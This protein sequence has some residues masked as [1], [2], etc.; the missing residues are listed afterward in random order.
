MTFEFRAHKPKAYLWFGIALLIIILLNALLIQALQSLLLDWN[1]L[2]QQSVILV[3]PWILF[4]FLPSVFTGMFIYYSLAKTYRFTLLH[5]GF[6]IQL[7]NSKKES[8]GDPKNFQWAEIKEFRFSDFEDNEYF[9][10]VFIDVKN[11]L[12]LHR[13]SGP[14]EQFFEELKKYV[15]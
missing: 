13:E 6:S 8:T 10:L 15:N 1:N 4:L 3:V 7:L 5:S 14:F 12:I 9:T 11:N 2:V